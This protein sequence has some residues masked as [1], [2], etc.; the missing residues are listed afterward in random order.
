MKLRGSTLV[1]LAIAVMYSVTFSA[2]ARAAVVS[3]RITSPTDP[4]YLQVDENDPSDPANTLTISGTTVDDGTPGNVDIVCYGTFGAN[5]LLSLT[6][7]GVTYH[8]TTGTFSTSYT[9]GR[10]DTGQTCTLRAI[11]AGTS[12]FDVQPFVGPRLGI[13]GFDTFTLA[14]GQPDDFFISDSQ[15]EGY[16]DYVSF[17][18]GGMYDAWPYDPTTFARGGDLF[19]SND[20]YP[21]L[22]ATGVGRSSVEVDGVSAFGPASAEAFCGFRCSLAGFPTLT[23]S[24][25]FD[26]ATG[27]VTINESDPLVACAPEPTVYPPTT[28]SCTSFVP[29]HVTVD[30]TIQQSAGGLQATITDRY[31]ST[32]GAAHRLDLISIEDARQF[33][34]GFDFPWVD[35]TTFNTHASGSTEPA[36]PGPPATVYVAYDNTLADG[37]RTGAQGAITFSTPPDAFVFAPSGLSG[38]THLTAEFARTVPASGALTLTQVF[39]WA[40]SKAQAQTLAAQAEATLHAP[41][42]TIASPVNGASVPGSPVTVSG[43]ATAAAGDGGLASLTVNGRTVAVTSGGAWS[44]SVALAPGAKAI[45]AVAT[46]GG[47]NRSQARITVQ[48]PVAS[49]PPPQLSLGGRLRFSSGSVLAPLRCHS[50]G[51]DCAGR[52]TVEYVRTFIARNHQLKLARKRIGSISYS[53]L[54]GQAKTIRAPLNGRGKSLLRRLHRLRLSVSITLTQPD[55]KSATAFV[56]SLKITT[57]HKRGHR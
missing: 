53:L 49:P 6:N 45:T 2:P 44:T 55:G 14:S 26:K 34:A 35:G 3:S 31:M 43:T 32:D 30:R 22:S 7:V 40:F 8:G 42:V 4:T 54:A 20:A 52:V 12:P 56:R 50:G 48:V 18:A 13:S 16:G 15:L 1:A 29:T 33:L 19:Y 9:L 21:A 37:D 46:D 39:S 5:P 23:V 36:P 10:F 41:T 28:A 38:L 11:P 47:G 27:E 51:A 25:S 57:N 17:S 24:D